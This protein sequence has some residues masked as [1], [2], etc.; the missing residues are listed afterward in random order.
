MRFSHV[1]LCVSDLDRS[2]EFY[3]SAFGFEREVRWRMS[4]EDGAVDA[5]LG[6]DNTVVH[7]QYLN[8]DGTL[9][10]LLWFEHP[11]SF[12]SRD[13]RSMNQFGL[14]HLAFRVEDVDAASE[15]IAAAGGRVLAGTRTTTD[16]PHAKGVTLFCTDPDGTRLELNYRVSL[17]DGGA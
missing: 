11:P 9:L 16:L 13:P 15:R 12:G 5:A 4:S 6:T 2:T 7:G 8:L 17:I 3:C 10:E 14:T 1:G